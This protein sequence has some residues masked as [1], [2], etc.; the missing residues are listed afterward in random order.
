VRRGHR[1]L[2]ELYKVMVPRRRGARRGLHLLL[3]VGDGAVAVQDACGRGAAGRTVI[4]SPP[5]PGG[6][7]LGI[8]IGAREDAGP[9]S[10][11]SRLFSEVAAL[12]RVRR[13]RIRLFPG[14]W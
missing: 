6:S 8:G 12:E 5:A 10:A 3:H 4:L 1:D 7:R 13:S 2:V 14:L 11:R 9:A